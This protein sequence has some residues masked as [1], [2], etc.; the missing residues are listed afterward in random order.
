MI[1]NWIAK[2]T[3]QLEKGIEVSKEIGKR[4]LTPAAEEA[5]K[6]ILDSMVKLE[7]INAQDGKKAILSKIIESED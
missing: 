7:A 6:G 2:T 3:K 5:D 1:D 4:K